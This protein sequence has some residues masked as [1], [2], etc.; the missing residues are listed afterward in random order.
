MSRQTLGLVGAG[1]L[2]AGWML[3]STVS[4]P[5]AQTQAGAPR[6]AV[7]VVP[8]ASAPSFQALQ[9]RVGQPPPT[10]QSHRNPFAF[11]MRDRAEAPAAPAGEDVLSPD[12]EAPVVPSVLRLVGVAGDRT[13]HGLVRTAILSDGRDVWLLKAGDTLPDGRTIVRVDDEAVVVAGLDG[14]ERLIRLR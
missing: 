12:V 6:R 5:V 11:E 13:D 9:W 3:A 14:A 2:L 1:S 8:A 4:P 10:P 7:P